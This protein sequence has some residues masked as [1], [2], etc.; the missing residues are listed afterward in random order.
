MPPFVWSWTEQAFTQRGL[1]SCLLVIAVKP[2]VLPFHDPLEE[3][4]VGPVFNNSNTET[5]E[6]AF[7]S[8]RAGVKMSRMRTAC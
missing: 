4:L 1:L 7:D 6:A 3:V 5:Q 8:P 2:G